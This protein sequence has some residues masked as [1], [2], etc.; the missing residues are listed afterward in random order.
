MLDIVFPECMNVLNIGD[1]I[2]VA[3]AKFKLKVKIL[4]EICSTN[5]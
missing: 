3:D 4:L 1:I 5:E 2:L